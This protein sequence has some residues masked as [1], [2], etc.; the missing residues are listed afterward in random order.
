MSKKQMCW[1]GFTELNAC[2]N[3]V[4]A[5][6]DVSTPEDQLVGSEE[7]QRGPDRPKHMCEMICVIYSVVN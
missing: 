3:S 7:V 4:A 6:G 1:G 5:S 2:N